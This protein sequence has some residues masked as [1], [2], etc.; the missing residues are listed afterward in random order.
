ML[1]LLPDFYGR[2]LIPTA[3]AHELETGRDAGVDLPAVHTL[4]WLTIRAPR[5]S[6]PLTVVKDLGAGEKEALWLATEVS[7]SILV[8]DDRL[9][10]TCAEALNLR[11]T[12]TLGLLLRAKAE[13]RIPRM[14]TVP[15]RLIE[16]KFRLSKST[17][18]AVLKLAGECS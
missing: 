15:E 11:F 12:G 16:L 5:S 18:D 8:L 13:G 10:R 14:E 4:T 6:E 3:V 17:Y 9:A 7:N 1:D 2:V